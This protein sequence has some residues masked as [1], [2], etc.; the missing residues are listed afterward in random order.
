MRLLDV[1]EKVDDFSTQINLEDAKLQNPNA[2]IGGE[3]I[4][5][6]LPLLILGELLLKAQSKSFFKKLERLREKDI[7]KNLK[8]GLVKL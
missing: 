3:P 6:E 4:E 2:E 5:E 8:I 7:M 1:V